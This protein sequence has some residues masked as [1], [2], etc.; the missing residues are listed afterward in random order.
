MASLFVDSNQHDQKPAKANFFFNYSDFWLPHH[1]EIYRN[2]IKLKRFY[3]IL[4]LIESQFSVIS[5]T[6][7]LAKMICVFNLKYKTLAIQFFIQFSKITQSPN[8]F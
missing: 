3:V 1:E 8:T 7:S 2:Y 4:K 5:G 6:L